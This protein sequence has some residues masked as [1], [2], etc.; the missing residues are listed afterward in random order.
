LS[1]NALRWQDEP[2]VFQAEYEGSIPFTRSNICSQAMERFNTARLIAEK[3]REDHLADL[4]S[5]HLDAD[6]SRYLGGVRSPDA[7]RAYLKASMAHWGQYGFGLWALK[8]YTGEFAGRAGLRHV[9]VDD[10]DEIEIAYTLKRSL[11][12]QGLA[13]EIASALT[14]VGLSRLELPSLVGLVAVENK[15][16]RRVLEKINFTLERSVIFRGEEVV[17]YRARADECRSARARSEKH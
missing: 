6:V 14:V 16:S 11:W 15:A 17:L 8:T 4:V 10:V 3:M 5:L 13:S 9:I 12:G 7:T 2:N 1:E